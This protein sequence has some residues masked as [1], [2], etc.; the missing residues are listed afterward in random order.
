MPEAAISFGAH[1][2]TGNPTLAALNCYAEEYPSAGGKR[3]AMRARAGLEAFKTVGS[4]P[5]RAAHQKDGI[6]ANA[7][8]IVSG[9]GVYLLAADGSLT[10]LAGSIPGDDPVDVD[11]GQDADLVSMAYGAT[12]EG[13]YLIQN[14]I[15][16]R[17]AFPDASDDVG[18][19]S[20]CYHRGF[21]FATKAG[22]D[23]AYYK[24]PGDTTW[25]P[26][27]F[28]SAE[29]KPDPLVA[30]RSRG[31]QFA[32]LGS[33]TFEAWALSGQADPAIVPYGGLNFD[34]GCRYGATAVNCDGTLM[35][36]DNRCQVRAWAGGEAQVVSG[37][38]LAELIRKVDATDLRAWTFAADGHLF[39]VLTLGA[40]STW[41]YDLNGAGERWTTFGSIG[42][43]YWR[44]HLG[45]SIG[46]TVLAADRISS[47][48]YRLDPDRRTDG[49]DQFIVEFCAMIEGADIP[50]PLNNVA[51]LCDLG[52]VPRDGQGSEPVIQMAKSANQGKTFGEWQERPLG[53]TGDYTAVPIWNAIGEV[54]RYLGVI[55]KFRVADPVGRIFK[56]V[57]VNT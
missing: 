22:T 40:N 47:Q 6:F 42:Y 29:Y 49:T 4:G 25:A 12:G 36:V 11:S 53:Q 3:I 20:V 33:S 14:G 38:G 57:F 50:Q 48:I 21:W 24:I 19:T 56:R 35:Y 46:G 51:V 23:Q 15:V 27:S 45:C 54:P 17:E 26:L 7:A 10:T 9:T 28:A 34:H 55:L 5:I 2:R 39:Y 37:P 1:E 43:D 41:V 44:A 18:A 13:L 8:L 16:S 52:D 31:D 32:L 30:I